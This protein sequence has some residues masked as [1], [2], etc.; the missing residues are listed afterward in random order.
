MRRISITYKLTILLALL[1]AAPLTYVVFSTSAEDIS[2]GTQQR[3]S[4][5]Q[6]LAFSCSLHLPDSDYFSIG[7]VIDSFLGETERVEKIRLRRFDGL[8][9]HSSAKEG[10]APWPKVDT[11]KSTSEFIKVPILRNNRNWGTLEVSYE[12]DLAQ[13][14]L[15]K[16]AEAFAF[17]VSINLLTF[18]F[19]L[20]RSLSVLDTS[21]VMPRR[22]R[23]TLD[24]IAGGVVI[25]DS[26]AR[27]VMANEAFQASSGI[28]F[29]N[30]VG[31]P[32]TEVEFQSEDEQL[33][34]DAALK[35]GVRKSG[36]T[37]KYASADVE[38]SFVVN[39]TPIFDS[40]EKLAGALVS[41]EDV[42]RLE[43]QKESL[44]Q[45]LGELKNSKEQ[46]RQQNVELQKLAS[47]DALT[48]CVNR[49]KLFELLE[50]GWK[51]A[52]E[53]GGQLNCIMLDVDHFKNLNDTHGHAVGDEVL[54]GVANSLRNSVGSAGVVGRYGGEEFC[55]VLSGVS[56]AEASEIGETIRQNLQADLAD[57]YQVTASFGVS[58][59]E[60]GAPS[61]QAM[62]E[63]ADQALYCAKH[64]GRNA[65]RLW[66]PDLDDAPEVEQPPSPAY[67]D[68]DAAQP[69]SYHA[70]SSL[71]AALAYRDADTALHSQRVAE[72]GVALGRGLMPV[73]ELYVLEIAGLLHD[74][75]KVGVPD[76]VLLKPASLTADEWK[77]MEAH[78]GIGVEIVQSSFDSPQLS[79]IVRY[80]HNRFDGSNVP[81]GGPVGEDIPIGARIVCIVDAFD[82][83]VTNRVYRKGRSAEEA[84]KELRRC[85]G[86][87]FDPELVERFIQLRIGWQPDSRFVESDVQDKLAVAVGHLT[88]RTMHAY[89][90][91]NLDAIT[92]SLNKLVTTGEQFEMPALVSL[93]QALEL[94]LKEG[95]SKVGVWEDSV[96]ILQDLLE[97]CLTVQRAHIRSVGARPQN[98]EGSPQ[99]SYFHAARSGWEEET[100]ITKTPS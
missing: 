41:F 18:G 72:M 83:M 56:A 27:V 23:N 3:V 32:L 85:A 49:R 54:K 64:G 11:Q 10:A 55:V 7:H 22:V 99:K 61:F 1:S 91:Q 40:S 71:H 51:T 97:V 48:Q 38:L 12:D 4:A 74:I 79:D 20:R 86:T 5:C 93:A 66:S 36:A 73:G 70:V 53:E 68:D 44:L 45:T 57:P 96:P 67:A 16:C 95:S 50:T 52:K 80:H 8:V 42:T 78:A 17:T 82:A 59:T 26:R 69:I 35:Q 81:E 14:H 28:S 60:L 21:K 65:V 33:P 47:V 31:K 30:L 77:V 43:E 29:E 76:A 15:R 84:F 34:W 37:L 100:G 19:L 75:G 6:Q 88:E 87:Q 58:S 46:I 92:D 62:L 24:T 9:V 98:T 63:Q 89:E 25:L 94:S 39:A 2:E 90:E 13:S